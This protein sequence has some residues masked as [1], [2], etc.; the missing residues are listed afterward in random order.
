MWKFARIV[1]QTVLLAGLSTAHLSAKAAN[2]FTVY[3]N[4]KLMK[5]NGNDGDS[6]SVAAPN[7][8]NQ[9]GKPIEMVVRLYGVDCMETNDRADYMK[10]RLTDQGLYFGMHGIDD[11]RN[12]FAKR[13]KLGKDATAFTKRSLQR[14]FTVITQN[15]PAMGQRPGRVY[16]YIIT[17]GGGDLGK[18]LVRNG[19]ARVYGKV[20]ARSDDEA[21]YQYLEELKMEEMHAI[22]QKKGGWRE[23]DWKVFIAERSQYSKH[24]GKLFINR[25][26]NNA[27]NAAIIAQRAEVNLKIA[28]ALLDGLKDGPY[29]NEKDLEKRV[30]GVGPKTAE[31]LGEILLFD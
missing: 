12:K 18:L 14:P 28:Q 11:G 15:A 9:K 13:I 10:A 26:K 17:H 7:P 21:P 5:G 6:F 30:K 27:F 24:V 16:A 20:D 19:L 3:K 31:K 2:P 23:T 22:N 29:K 8:A 1:I 25:L 4:C